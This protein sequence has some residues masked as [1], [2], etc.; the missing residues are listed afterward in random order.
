MSRHSRAKWLR[1]VLLVCALGVLFFGSVAVVSGDDVTVV[2]PEDTVVAGEETILELQVT[3]RGTGVDEAMQGTVV[4]L[5]SGDA[6]LTIRTSGQSLGNLPT[7]SSQPVAFTVVVDE[8]ADPG[9]YDL[10]AEI[11]TA[12]ETTTETV[13]VTVEEQARFAVVDSTTD[14]HVG[15]PGTVELVL[16]NVGTER[17]RNATVEIQSPDPGFDIG[18]GTTFSRTF[19]GEWDVGENRTVRVAARAAERTEA[20]SH[21]LDVTVRFYD[22]LGVRR[23]DDVDD[24][25]VDVRPKQAFSV[26][27]VTSTLRVGKDGRV[28][29]TVRNEGLRRAGNVVAVLESPNPNV[30]IRDPE[31]FVGTLDPG[32][33]ERISF[34]VGLREDAEPDERVIP[35][36]LR[37]RTPRDDNVISDQLDVLVT[38]EEEIEPFEV[39]SINRTIEQGEEIAYQVEVRNVGDEQ[40]SD[41]EAQLFANPPLGTTDSEAYV[42]TLEPGETTVI[43]FGL[44]AESDATPKTYPVSIDFRYEDEIGDRHLTDR[45][46]L[47]VE[48]VESELSPL[49]IGGVLAAVAVLFGV[50]YWKR[51][52][53]QDRV[54]GPNDR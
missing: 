50:G 20:R 49:V 18:G 13:E 32:G 37:Y 43:T 7:G 17:A 53:I 5:D 28:N 29:V 4:E 27:N 25:G 22:D 21:A 46:R 44:E 8:D 2:L 16:R 42:S 15:E 30:A 24:S 41:I 34:R 47:P 51:E 26:T 40:F 11:S 14:A 1:S 9:T 3:N 31:Q 35:L 39:E 52:R 6:P 10:E 33:S 36:V 23:S 45:Y 12:D 48:V 54:T 38:V 19:E